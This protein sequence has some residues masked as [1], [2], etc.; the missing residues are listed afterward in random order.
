[1]EDLE[2]KITEEIKLKDK[3]NDLG[4]KFKGISDEKIIFADEDNFRLKFQN[5][6]SVKEWIENIKSFYGRQLKTV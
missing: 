1:M 3:M 6:G 2:K 5:W 4:Y